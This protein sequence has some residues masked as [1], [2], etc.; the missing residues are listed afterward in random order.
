MRKN[1]VK[2]AQANSIHTKRNSI[3]SE[4]ENKQT[5]LHNSFTNNMQNAKQ[6]SAI[7]N[8]MLSRSEKHLTKQK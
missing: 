8:L 7:T 5:I 2:C 4:Q 6:K 1:A 3:G